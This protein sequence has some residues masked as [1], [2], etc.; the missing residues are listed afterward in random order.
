[1]S[2]RVRLV[3]VAAVAALVAAAP[4]AAGVELSGVDTSS[5]PTIHATVVSSAGPKAVPV[6][7]E[8]GQRVV[9]LDAENLSSEKAVVLAVDNSQSMQ[10]KPLAA[11]VAAA[12]SFVA[13]KPAA[14]AI[15]VIDFGRHP[16]QLSSLSTADI[17]SDTALAS[18]ATAGESGTA[19]YDG[20]GL[21]A[22][23]LKASSLPGRVLIV[24][25]DGRD[26]SSQD[27]LAAAVAA[28]HDANV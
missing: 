27:S 25:T 13:A 5:F 21:A 7:T 16:A 8:N 28:A 11:A 15:A 17:D 2:G 10:G 3:A 20:V 26:V 14:D 6:I 12:R 1:M 18:I 23:I 9:G 22:S 24:L 4:A 19:L